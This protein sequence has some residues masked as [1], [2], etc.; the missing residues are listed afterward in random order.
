VKMEAAALVPA[1]NEVGTIAAVVQGVLPFVSEGLVVDDGST[2]GTADAAR[3]AGAGVVAHA[4]NRG[5]GHAVRTGLAHLL[6]G[7]LT[8]VVLLDG[9]LQHVP[10]ETPRLIDGSIP[11]ACLLRGI[12]RT[13]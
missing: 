10:Q 12:T 2:D 6:R 11:R 8:H 3:A 9:D 1:Y 4:A 13:V 5:K 7:T